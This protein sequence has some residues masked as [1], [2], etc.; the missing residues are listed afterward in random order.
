MATTPPSGDG[1][2]VNNGH[3]SSAADQDYIPSP[4]TMDEADHLTTGEDPVKKKPLPLSAFPEEL[5]LKICHAIFPGG[6][7][8]STQWSPE[9]RAALFHL[10]R[11]GRTCKKL[12]RIA[13]EPLY[14]FIK[15]ES[16]YP[17]TLAQLLPYVGIDGRALFNAIVGNPKLGELIKQIEFD[18][19]SSKLQFWAPS[20]RLKYQRMNDDVRALCQFMIN[21]PATRSR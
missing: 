16:F 6:K 21:D 5:L 18:H 14:R 7:H 8:Q 15:V 3:P 2:A 9:Y 10:S 11:L 4:G 19:H 20:T 13:R 1:H 17:D 12:S